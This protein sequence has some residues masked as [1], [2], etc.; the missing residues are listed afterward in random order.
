M[1]TPNVQQD[2][3]ARDNVSALLRK[4]EPHVETLLASCWLSVFWQPAT[5]QPFRPRSQ[6]S[7]SCSIRSGAG[8]CWLPAPR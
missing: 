2:V 8:G 6:R 1:L 4:R 3:A 7:T 5:V